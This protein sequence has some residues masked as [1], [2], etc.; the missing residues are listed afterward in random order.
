M[1]GETAMRR[2]RMWMVPE[3]NGERN[4][5]CFMIRSRLG[6]DGGWT[7][8]SGYELRLVEI[9]VLVML[10]VEVNARRALESTVG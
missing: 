9:Q 5:F 10:R 8:L 6:D 3:S 7:L 4:D 1:K 2:G